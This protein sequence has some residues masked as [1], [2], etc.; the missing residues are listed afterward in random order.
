MGTGSFFNEIYGSLL[1]ELIN[2]QE[3]PVVADLGAGYGKFGYF[4]LRDIERFTFIDFDLPETLCLAAYYLMKAWPQKRVLLFGEED[5]SSLSHKRYDLIFMPCYEIAK[6][7]E[8]SVDL[9]I[10]KHSLGEMTRESVTNY[11]FH[12]SK[13][14]RYFFHMNHDI[15]PQIYSDGSSGMLGHEYP[16]PRDKFKLLFRVPEIG[17]ALQ[18]RGPDFRSDIFVYLYERRL[19]TVARRQTTPEAS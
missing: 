14:S 16:V 19:N 9:F 7:G 12:I 10:N 8:S 4:A 11:V 1:S 15:Y 3:A 13:A 6:L 18:R 2:D 5:Y 17:N